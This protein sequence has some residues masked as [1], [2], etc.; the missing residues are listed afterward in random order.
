M[1]CHRNIGVDTVHKGDTDD[2]DDDDNN[3]NN[4]NNNLTQTVPL[5]TLLYISVSHPLQSQSR[6]FSSLICLPYSASLSLSLP[7][8]LLLVAG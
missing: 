5:L 4:N 7:L 2:D 1:V 6:L 8:Y 3:N